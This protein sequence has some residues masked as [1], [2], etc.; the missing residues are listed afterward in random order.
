M[1]QWRQGRCGTC[2]G[3]A[4]AQKL[5]PTDSAG[6]KVVEY[7]MIKSVTKGKR[8]KHPTNLVV[9]VRHKSVLLFL[10]CSSI[11]SVLK[12]YTAIFHKDFF[13]TN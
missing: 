5:V 1:W 6:E 8:Q 10:Q 3:S 7:V 2:S 9:H 4:Q 11:Y 13:Q 12:N